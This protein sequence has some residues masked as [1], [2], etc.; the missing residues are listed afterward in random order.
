LEKV[1]SSFRY[2]QIIGCAGKISTTLMDYVRKELQTKFKQPQ[3]CIGYEV[4]W[5]GR[6]SPVIIC[7][8]SNDNCMVDIK[9]LI[10]MMYEKCLR[11][12]Q[13]F[14]ADVMKK[15][16]NNLKTKDL[17]IL[18]KA[19][20]ASFLNEAANKDFSKLLSPTDPLAQTFKP[21][22]K[23][24]AN[25]FLVQTL[26]GLKDDINN[27][28]LANQNNQNQNNQVN[29]AGAN[30]QVSPTN[31][32]LNSPSNLGAQELDKLNKMQNFFMT[33]LDKKLVELGLNPDGTAKAV[34]IVSPVKPNPMPNVL[35]KPPVG[36]QTPINNINN[37]FKPNPTTNVLPNTQIPIGG[38]N[39]L[40]NQGRPNT[41]A[42][43][44]IL[45]TNN[46][47]GRPNTV[48]MGGILPTN[49]PQSLPNNIIPNN[50]STNPII[51][52]LI[53]KVIANLPKQIPGWNPTPQQLAELAKLIAANPDYYM[54]LLKNGLNIPLSILNS[55][56]N[57]INNTQSL[58]PCNNNVNNIF[59]LAK[60]INPFP[61]KSSN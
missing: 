45:P 15:N 31:A 52:D 46:L 51:Q 40:N 1:F 24:I 9:L 19:K 20:L 6:N 28:K 48:G 56:G 43:N 57:S 49:N 18:E 10:S 35:P 61:F 5:Q 36:M 11:T 30:T 34:P 47:Q 53:N 60:N 33:M 22:N 54:N 41:V 2:D 7:S 38:F 23:P 8:T 42:T 44:G 55:L 3:C 16:N 26:L 17:S 59:I 12:Q 37:Q 25:Q 14:F 58:P 13:S 50:P 27:Q 29:P 21:A 4:S 32:S 39:A